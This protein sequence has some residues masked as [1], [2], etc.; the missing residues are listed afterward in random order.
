VTKTKTNSKYK[1]LF[2]ARRFPPSVGGMERFA[3]DLS[4]A[5][6]RKVDLQKIT[7]GGS[8]K[9]LPLVLP[10]FFLKAS[11]KLL[12]DRHIDIIHIQDAVQA[13]IGWLLHVLFNRPYIVVAHGLD[14][15][16]QNRFY[17]MVI[18]PFVRRAD[19][20]I[21]IS[22]ATK[23][24]AD[25]RGVNTALSDVITLGTHDDYGTV[26]VDRQLLAQQIDRDINGKKLLL[27]TGRLV[28]RKGVEWF[29]LNV[30][31]EVVKKDKS[32]L[33]LI[34]G[35]GA[36]RA[37]IERAIE[38][39]KLNDHIMMLGRV[40]DEARSTLY[41]SCD[42]FIMPNI[43]VAGDMEGFGIVAHEA[44][45]A[46]LPVVASDLEGIADALTD[47]KNG[48]LLKSRDADSYTK[49]VLKLLKDEKSRRSFGKKART[50]T[51]A[52]YS[53]EKIAVQYVA[54]YKELVNKRRGE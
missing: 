41:Q 7:W 32:V 15:T 12:T 54:V 42:M 22:T 27:T 39:T 24:E 6:G 14:I 46:G 25:K 2:I 48:I 52:N 43:V 26:K 31:P 9:L 36:E 40:S 5:L 19:R 49:N 16:Y 33:Y 1:V 44:A 28:K 4:N 45:T 37:A 50:Y 20:V 18:L 13:P 23:I 53:W 3:F 51:L 34:V 17:Q 47:G 11:F 21:S 38:K 35:D 29:I 8:N 10:F 30:L